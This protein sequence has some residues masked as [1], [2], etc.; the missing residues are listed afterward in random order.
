MKDNK[1]QRAKYHY[2]QPM[3]DL[4]KDTDQRGQIEGISKAPSE[5][6]T[7]D[8]GSQFRSTIACKSVDT[9][10]FL[11]LIITTPDENRR[12]LQPHLIKPPSPRTN[13]VP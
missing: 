6:T 5:A 10:P 13:V 3:A 12:K 2:V 8:R 11:Q 7:T 9:H 4:Q 1:G